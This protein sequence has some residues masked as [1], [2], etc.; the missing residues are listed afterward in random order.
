MPTFNFSVDVLAKCDKVY[1]VLKNV[2]DYKNFMNSV[3]EVKV[4]SEKN[5][6]LLTQ[7]NVVYDGVPIDWQEEISFDDSDY[8]V[9]FKSVSG[10]YS[11]FGTWKI[12]PNNKN[13]KTSISLEITYDWDAPNFEHYFGDVYKQ[14]AEKATKGMIYALKK[15]LSI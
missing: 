5:N 14:K 11:R 13:N 15:R 8:S 10:N 6:L 3:Q 4:L 12:S 2:S 7:W 9:K 1:S